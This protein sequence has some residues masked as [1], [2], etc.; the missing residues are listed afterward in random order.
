MPS[1]FIFKRAPGAN[2]WTITLPA[3]GAINSS[4][5]AIVFLKVGEKI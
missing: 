4:K 2:K 1:L 5:R 3:A